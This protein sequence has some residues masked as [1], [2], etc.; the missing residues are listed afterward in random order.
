MSEMALCCDWVFC[1]VLIITPLSV[2][3]TIVT[4]KKEKQK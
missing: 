2:A 1:M 4:G 3:E